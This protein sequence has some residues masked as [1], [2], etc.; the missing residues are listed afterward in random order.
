MGGFDAHLR[1]ILGN[2]ALE[3]VKKSRVLLVGAGGIGCELLKDLILMNY[4]EIH[5]A[6]L[7]TI[8][9]S[10]LNRQF[11][12]RQK[13]IKKP[14]SLTAVKAVESFNHASK[15]VAYHG[16]ITDANTYPLDWFCQFDTIFN[17][18]DNLEARVYV[19]R[20]ALFGNIPLMESGTSGLNGQVR[21]ILP[22]QSECFECT[23]V[24]APKTFPVCTIR[25]TPSKPIHCI[26]WAKNF[27]FSQLF[28]EDGEQEQLSAADLDTEDDAEVEALLKESNELLDLKRLIKEAGETSNDEFVFSIVTKIFKEDIE[29]LLRI[30]SLWKSGAK[31]EPLDVDSTRLQL[32]DVSSDVLAN[33]QGVWTLI[34]SLYVLVDST[35][36]LTKRWASERNIPFDKDDK[37]TLDFVVAASNLRS[38]CFHIEALSRF[39]LKQIAGN[40]I[41]AVATT[42][43][44]M[45]GL[46]CLQSINLLTANPFTQLRMAFD[47]NYPDRFV[48]P[49]SLS[50]PSPACGACSLRRGV[51]KLH[52]TSTLGQVHDA[53]V[54]KYKFPDD[55]SIIAKSRLIY[56]DDF[57]D[58]LVRTVESLGIGLGTTLFVSDLDDDFEGIALYV[59]NGTGEGNDVEC[60]TDFELVPKR[61]P[62]TADE[63]VDDD[64]EEI[65]DDDLTV[66][67]DRKHTLDASEEGTPKKV[68]RS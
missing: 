51:L 20:M 4:G 24:E 15:L 54:E 31:P 28:G 57:D 17:A 9:L 65:V 23:P 7:D 50:K 3:K 19:N 45:A 61:E 41:P 56:D 53:I 2:E 12:F 43:A 37:D 55:I 35:K 47:S 34:E 58:N 42:N 18:L 6:D 33:D 63:G 11:L 66:I 52:P 67:E 49:S 16:N 44:I 26:I 10:N 39:K 30:Q 48:V 40:I 46:S 62:A 68:K 36:R 32:Q 59:T 29:R 13:D 64:F 5:V 1:R 25:S 21:P 38:Y 22:Y 60:A 14:K 27:L 8:D